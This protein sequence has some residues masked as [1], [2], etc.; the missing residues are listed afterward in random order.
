M[1]SCQ[2]CAIISAY[3]FGHACKLVI[4]LSCSQLLTK[5][6]LY[7]FAVRVEGSEDV[8]AGWLGKLLA[9]SGTLGLAILCNKALFPV[10]APITLGLTP[11]VARCEIG[12]VWPILWLQPQLWT[13][14]LLKF[15]CCVSFATIEA[16]TFIFRFLRRGPKVAP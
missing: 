3:L 5:V 16:H 4:I 2:A 15:A 7:G 11:V 14:V 12:L 9:S 10:R 13:C 8:N 1:G 6:W